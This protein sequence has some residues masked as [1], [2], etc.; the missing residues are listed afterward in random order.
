[1]LKNPKV[2]TDPFRGLT[3]EHNDL[4]QIPIW[5]IHC[6]LPCGPVI[7]HL[8]S[9]SGDENLTPGKGTKAPQALQLGQKRSIT[10]SYHS[11]RAIDTCIRN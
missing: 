4:T 10:F 7:K 11:M 1:M 3:R 9:K 8:P 6:T 5:K 2:Y